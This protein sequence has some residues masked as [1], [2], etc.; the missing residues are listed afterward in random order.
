L[1]TRR[2]NSAVLRSTYAL[3]EMPSVL[4]ASTFRSLFSSV[5]VRKKT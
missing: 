2:R 3:V 1:S 4:A 5:P